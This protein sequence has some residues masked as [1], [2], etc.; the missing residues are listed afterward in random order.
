MA[1]CQHEASAMEEWLYF[2]DTIDLAQLRF[3]KCRKKIKGLEWGAPLGR[4]R[5]FLR[6][7][8]GTDPSAAVNPEVSPAWT[9]GRD[10][11]LGGGC[12]K[13]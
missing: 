6:G 10:R 5:P 1:R 2:K 13:S 12:R 3:P 11:P 4:D 8:A 7:G 9:L